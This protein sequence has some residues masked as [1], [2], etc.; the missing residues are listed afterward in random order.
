MFVFLRRW[1]RL[2]VGAGVALG[3]LTLGFVIDSAAAADSNAWVLRDQVQ[4]HGAGV[5]LDEL[6]LG[7]ETNGV[8]HLRLCD[9]PVVG[10][11]LQLTL[12]QIRSLL[13]STAP[14]LSSQTWAG[15]VSVLIARRTR[16]LPE[17]EMLEA[18]HASLIKQQLKELTGDLDLRFSRPWNSAAVADEPYTLRILDL[19]PSG[20]TSM[21]Q[22]RFELMGERESLGM[23]QVGIEAK[24][25]RKVWVSGQPLKRGDE[26]QDADL[27]LERRD[28]LRLRDY[29]PEETDLRSGWEAAEVLNPGQPL[30]RRGVQLRA[31]VHRG[32]VVDALLKDGP[33]TIS[34]K[35]EVLDSGVPGQVVRLRNPI[36]R[37]EIRGKVINEQVVQIQL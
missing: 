12:T 1:T 27:T 19:P 30:T 33:V 13:G 9:A 10:R 23:W 5:F 16:V 17:S 25:W 37:R 7:S 20:L 18:L 3:V 35:A 24:L 31:V 21:M 14:A 32:Q 11:S 15:P 34:L 2:T 4:V 36:S 29:I 26:I 6:V 22:I 28:I 8:L